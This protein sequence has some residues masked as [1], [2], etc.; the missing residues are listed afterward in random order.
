MGEA[1]P[2]HLHDVGR[3]GDVNLKVSLVQLVH[4][5]L[6]TQDEFLRVTGLGEHDDVGRLMVFGYQEPAPERAGQ[7][8]LKTLRA[9]G[10]T[11]DR[12]YLV[13][14]LNLLRES[15]DPVQVAR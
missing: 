15:L 5:A 11:L 10:Q 6:Q 8:I 13:N 2:E 7:C 9:D 4:D 3:A 14:C 1:S 12:A